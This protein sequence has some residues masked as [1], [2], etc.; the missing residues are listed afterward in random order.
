MVP[1]SFASSSF[2]TLMR[3]FRAP[4]LSALASSFSS[5][6]PWASR[7]LVTTSVSFSTALRN[8]SLIS[9]L[10][11]CL[12]ALSVSVSLVWESKAGFSIW[13]FT[14]TR[15]LRFTWKGFSFFLCLFSSGF[16]A[17]SS[18][19]TWSATASTWV[20]PRSVQMEFTNDT[21]SNWPSLLLLTQTC[22]RPTRSYTRP[23]AA[24]SLPFF[25]GSGPR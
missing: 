22:Q 3:S 8:L 15:R 6:A 9:H 14:N 11:P 4:A 13:A 24:A 2:G 25:F 20:P 21:C 10:E 17:K 16:F 23:G 1:A 12:A 7:T 18:F 19:A 5:L